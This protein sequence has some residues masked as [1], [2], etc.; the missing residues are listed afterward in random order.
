MLSS[1]HDS[2]FI[3][4][5]CTLRSSRNSD[6]VT[7]CRPAKQRW[8][9]KMSQFSS[10]NLL[11]QKRLK[12]DGYMQMRVICLYVLRHNS[13][14]KR[15]LILGSGANLLFLQILQCTVHI[16]ILLVLPSPTRFSTVF[17]QTWLRYVWLM[18]WQIRLCVVCL[19]C[20]L[21]RACI[22]LTGFD[23][24]KIF[25]HHIVTWPSCNSPTKHHE[26]RPRESPALRKSS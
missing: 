11:S 22:L 25:L 15:S 26:D 4:V 18:L 21:W 6:G 2:L 19:V 5:M 10:N 1:P 17:S 16:I 20:R 24:S 9:M 13:K 7:P 3:L 23:F 12:I 14:L 8:G